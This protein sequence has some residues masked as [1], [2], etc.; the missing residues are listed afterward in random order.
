MNL[1]AYH[2]SVTLFISGCNRIQALRLTKMS[3]NCQGGLSPGKSD[4]VLVDKD[5]FAIIKIKIYLT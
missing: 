1:D 2:K 5:N 4:K 3:S